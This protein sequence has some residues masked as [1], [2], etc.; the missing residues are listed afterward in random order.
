MHSAAFAASDFEEDFD[1][2][3]KP[4]QEI[5]IQLPA[6]PQEQELLPFEVSGNTTHRFFIDPK[7]V[8]V[9]SDGVIR[10]TLVTVSSNGARN[11]SYEGL[12]CETFEVKRYAFGQPD[13]NWSRS[14]RDQWQW[15]VRNAANRQHAVLARDYMCQEKVIADSAE[16]IVARIRSGQSL[17]PSTLP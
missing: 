2:P 10:Y 1:D 7:S 11:I 12:R 8:S 14:K 16:R 9:G 17:N 4:W 5:A 3:N 13:G 6:A 15:I